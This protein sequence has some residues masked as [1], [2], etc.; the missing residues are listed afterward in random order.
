MSEK[1]ESKVPGGRARALALSPE[2]K[3]EIGA[4]GAMA[5]WGEKPLVAIHKGSFK[6]EFGVDVECYVLNDPNKTPV[7][8]QTGMARVLGLSARGS[9]FP[10]FI[11]SQSM[12]PYLGSE[13]REKL[14]K[15]LVFQWGSPGVG[16]QVI[17]AIHGHDA[18]LLIDICN[19]INAASNGGALKGA[20]YANIVRNASIINGAAAKSGIRGLVYALAGYNPAAEEVIQA[21][22]MYVREEAQRYEQEFPNELYVAW[23]R[24]YQIPVPVRG[25]PW[26]FAH[27]TRR[28]IYYPLANSK[29]TLYDL[30]RALRDRDAGKKKL[31]QFLS[32]IGTRALRMHMGRVVEMAESSR[33]KEE[34]EAWIARRFGEQQELDLV[35]TEQPVTVGANDAS[36]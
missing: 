33:T 35:G 12:A 8:S 15:L 10:S 36:V 14:Q 4:K 27:L 2:R 25:K 32:D 31:F 18:A 11:N 24:L 22:K 6:E 7:I 13:L 17:P 23:H 1:D 26:A 16:E 19:A 29:G 9:S 3:K 5:R 34:Y 28:H 21:F 30:L 20:R